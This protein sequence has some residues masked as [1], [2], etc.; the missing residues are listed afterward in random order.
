MHTHSVIT[1]AGKLGEGGGESV[2]GVRVL[3]PLALLR[4]LQLYRVNL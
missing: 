4:R 3:L 1:A 2:W